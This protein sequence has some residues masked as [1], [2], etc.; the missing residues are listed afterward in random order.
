MKNLY[1]GLL[2]AIIMGFGSLHAQEILVWDYSGSYTIP[3]PDQADNYQIEDAVVAALEAND[4]TPELVF[5]LP[6]DLSTYDAIFV[7][8][9]IWCYS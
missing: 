2:V 7:L 5:T 6:E 1:L 3:N 4:I 8:G 9:G